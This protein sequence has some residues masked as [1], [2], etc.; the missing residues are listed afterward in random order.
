[1]KLSRIGR[2]LGAAALFLWTYPA[3][4]QGLTRARTILESLQENL[5]ILVPIF[6]VVV[7]IAIWAM[8]SARWMERDSFV[9]WLIGLV[10]VASVAQLVAMFLL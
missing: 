4:A 9:R 3:T 2:R 5:E 1:M 6:A 10:G 7:G 8:Y